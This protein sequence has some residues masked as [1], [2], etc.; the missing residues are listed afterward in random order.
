MKYTQQEIDFLLS[1]SWMCRKKVTRLF[2]EKFGKDKKHESIKTFY[3]RRGLKRDFSKSPRVANSGTFKKGQKAH[4]EMEIGD[5]YI[6]PRNGLI[7]I[8]TESGRVLKHHHVWGSP[9]PDGYN[10]TF[11]DGNKLNCAKDNLILVPR[12]AMLRFNQSFAKK[13]TP[14]SRESLLLL[15]QIKDT[16]HKRAS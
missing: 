7:M 14:K 11:R 9:I 2:N 13:A 1:V 12:S 3:V 15:A 10:L 16:L 4:N 5:E 6:H 8:K